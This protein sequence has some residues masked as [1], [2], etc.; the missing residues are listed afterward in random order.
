MIGE[1]WSG[2][3]CQTSE[4]VAAI[5]EGRS[6]SQN[7][8]IVISKV[9]VIMSIVEIRCVSAPGG[10]WSWSRDRGQSDLRVQTTKLI[11]VGRQVT[12]EPGVLITPG[13]HH[14]IRVVH[15]QLEQTRNQSEMSIFCVNQSEMSIYLGT[16]PDTSNTATPPSTSSKTPATSNLVEDLLNLAAQV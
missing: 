3:H 1:D 2:G 15:M 6:Q 7:H 14:I 12:T 9:Q 16:S 11:N 13:T 8:I 5:I 10:Q 4:V